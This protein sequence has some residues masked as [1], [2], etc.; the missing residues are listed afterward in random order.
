MTL[1]IITDFTSI[2]EHCIVY[3]VPTQCLKVTKWKFT[4]VEWKK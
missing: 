3:V 4:T 1:N 2:A